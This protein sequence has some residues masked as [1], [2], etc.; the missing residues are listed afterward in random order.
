MLIP[1]NFYLHSLHLNA[2]VKPR[3]ND[4]PKNF[5]LMRVSVSITGIVIWGTILFMML[6]FAVGI[7]FFREEFLPR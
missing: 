6:G 5:E 1:M 2:K 7:I 3:V 4:I